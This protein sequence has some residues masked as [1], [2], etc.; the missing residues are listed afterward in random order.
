[1]PFKSLKRVNEN[2][3]CLVCFAYEK[4][5]AKID[6]CS[7]WKL[8]IHMDTERAIVPVENEREVKK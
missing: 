8:N 7:G 2:L 6:I 1:M 5:K 4:K 3:D